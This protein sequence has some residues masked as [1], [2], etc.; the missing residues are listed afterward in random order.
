MSRF[1]TESFDPTQLNITDSDVILNVGATRNYTTINQAISSLDLSHTGRYFILVDPGTYDHTPA[2]F[3]QPELSGR[4]FILSASY[5]NGGGKFTS[6]VFTTNAYSLYHS[7][8]ASSYY[9]TAPDV[10]LNLIPDPNLNNQLPVGTQFSGVQSYIDLSSD[11]DFSQVSYGFIADAGFVLYLAG[12]Q[13]N[14]SFDDGN[15]VTHNVLY[16]LNG[17]NIITMD[18][19]MV[20][21]GG[22]NALVALMGSTI[23]S[24]RSIFQNI[25]NVCA[26]SFYGSTIMV[27][28]SVF[29]G[30]GRNASDIQYVEYTS[31]L[32]PSNQGSV[33]LQPTIGVCYDNSD[34]Y[35][36]YSWSTGFNRPLLAAYNGYIYCYSSRFDNY[37]TGNSVLYAQGCG[38]IQAY[39]CGFNNVGSVA[40]SIG[41]SVIELN[42]STINGFS[43]TALQA[44]YNAT[45]AAYIISGTTMNLPNFSNIPVANYNLTQTD[46]SIIHY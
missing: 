23:V 40:T 26:Y 32:N 41:L 38:N 42:D 35:I 18:G 34:L 16:A 43:G 29:I 9:N 10:I 30:P 44:I 15:N 28:T 7:A 4:L 46:N 19:S 13:L 45:I 8:Q 31:V 33:T 25:A 3:Y 6:S 14:G 20:Y 36:G 22:V 37:G 12:F 39:Y 11:T 17:A 27:N 5:L 2:Y 1:I 24:R 21:N